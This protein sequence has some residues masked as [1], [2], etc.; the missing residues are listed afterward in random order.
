MGHQER[1]LI[2][3]VSLLS[4]SVF[5]Y[6][7]YISRSPS[8]LGHKSPIIDQIYGSKVKSLSGGCLPVIALVSVG[9]DTVFIAVIL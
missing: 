6:F 8:T 1:L 4:F 7:V 3:A 5:V 2:L 9:F